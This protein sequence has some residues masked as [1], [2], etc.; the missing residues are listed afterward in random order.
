MRS[1]TDRPGVYPYLDER[2]RALRAFR[3]HQIEIVKDDELYRHLRF[4]NPDSSAYHFSL[5]TWPGYLAISGDI[6]SYM[7]CRTTD[8]FEWFA[9]TDD[10]AAMP[11]SINPGYWA[12]KCVAADT[13]RGIE[14]FDRD[15]FR[16]YVVTTYRDLNRSDFDP[17]ER[18]RIWK[19]VRSELLDPHFD[20]KSDAI[21]EAMRFQLHGRHQNFYPFED[22]WD[23]SFTRPDF[24][25]LMCCFAII[26]GIKRYA[27]V[28]QG[29][30]QAVEGR[31]IL[32]GAL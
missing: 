28:K 8:M 23:C 5:T 13:A 26:W 27:Q 7:F 30:D 11:I 18:L 12:E 20:T 19:D 17:G 15:S 6:G 24:G 16:E 21:N 9:S 1:K 3:H 2:K 29:R 14:E 4:R 22:A 32:E 10:M 31:L 25:F